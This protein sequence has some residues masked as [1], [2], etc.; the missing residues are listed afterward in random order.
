MVLGCNALSAAPK[1]S[2]GELLLGQSYAAAGPA[3]SIGANAPTVLSSGAPASSALPR[4]AQLGQWQQLT[5]QALMPS[6]GHKLSADS[7]TDTGLLADHE[8]LL[9]PE[10]A[11]GWKLDAQ[12]ASLSYDFTA[13]RVPETPL[14]QEVGSLVP[15]ARERNALDR[16]IVAPGVGF[17]LDQDSQID[18]AAVLA[19]QRFNSQ[20]LGEQVYS[21]DSGRYVESSAGAGLRIGIASSLNDQFSVNAA[22]QSRIDMDEFDGYRG[23]FFEPG[24][25]DIPAA[26]E[27]SFA[28][29]A[30][31]NL[32]FNVG[33][34]R[35]MYSQIDA[36]TSALL[37]QSI[38]SLLGDSS[39]PELIWSDLTV[40]R[41]GLGWRTDAN[42]VWRVDLSSTQ[43]PRPTDATLARA[44]EDEYDDGNITLGFT[45]RT[46]LNGWL[47]VRASYAPSQY[48]VAIAPVQSDR[49]D[50]DQEQL[51]VEL[52]WTLTF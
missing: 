24:D 29:S 3:W 26:A 22:V 42:R 9:I 16:L 43:Q 33:V 48:L 30:G 51:E 15:N 7:R 19:T 50:P 23:F 28:W 21:A 10:F 37:P 11:A 25:F 1:S 49:P 14:L 17:R 41:L 8:H 2:V 5:R 34:E 52:L 46:G 38:L 39:S 20:G 4:T 44:I 31:T 47:D 13:Y 32:S 6:F 35:V 12:R 27:V 40:A 36:V 45:Q 18:V